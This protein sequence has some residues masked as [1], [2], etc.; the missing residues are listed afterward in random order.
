VTG[1]ARRIAA[2]ASAL[3]LTIGCAGTGTGVAGA[4]TRA[5]ADP[6]ASTAAVQAA[7]AVADPASLGQ[8][9]LYHL[10]FATD[11]DGTPVDEGDTFEAGG[12]RVLTLVG[13]DYV[14]FGTE[15]RLRIFQGTRL[16]YDDTRTTS[17][18]DDGGY[19]FAYQPTGGLVTGAYAAELDYNGVPDEV[20]TFIVVPSGS[21]APAAVP[22]GT[23]TGPGTPTTGRPI[24][25]GQIPYAD[26]A[27]VLVVTRTAALRQKLGPRTDA[28]LAAAA[29]VGTVRDLD[30]DGVSRGTVDAAVTE[31]QRL[32]HAGSYRYLLILGNDDVVPYA[33]LPNPFADE[34]R[35]ALDS[36][37][38]PSDWVPSDDPYTDLDQDQWIVP[39]LPIARIPSSDDA[40]LLLKQLGQ[41][42]TP[43]GG[44][45][46]LLNQKRR[47]IAEPIL[48]RIDDSVSLER[49]YAPPTTPDELSRTPARSARFTYMLLH[50]IGVA[51]DS[52]VTD[53]VAWSPVDLSNLDGE[54]IVRDGNQQPAITVDQAGAPGGVVEIGACYG[55]WTLDTTEAPTHKTAQNDLALAYLKSGTRAY[56]ADTHISYSAP[57]LPDGTPVARTGFEL[58]FWQALLSGSSPID[59]FQA[60]KVGIAQALDKAVAAGDGDA[61]ALDFKT[62]EIMVYLGRP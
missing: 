38:L 43:E 18:E 3:V 16:V 25:T 6:G 17:R 39:D 33:H 51:T 31:V 27:T 26:P 62:L 46:A 32:L 50:G 47:S 53:I 11:V 29:K 41:N 21:G 12:P 8:A 57:L 59:A 56:I 42:V 60:A 34:E 58:L 52:W 20:A 45:F 55:A 40:D 7:P 23:T 9:V 48:G 37:E 22:S 30:A 24:L 5:A 44:A 14:P 28:V 61:A 4:T 2:A 15:L 49:H 36:W 54:W 10:D 13:W 35:D 1:R 19:I